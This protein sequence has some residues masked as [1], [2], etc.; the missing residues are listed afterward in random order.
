MAAI[1]AGL[2]SSRLV[3]NTSVSPVSSRT[4]SMRRST[5]GHLTSASRPLSRTSW[6]LTMLP[7]GM[8]RR[9]C[10]TSYSVCDF[11]RVTWNTPSNSCHGRWALAYDSDERAGA[12]IP[13]CASLPSQLLSPPS[14]SRSECAR[15][16]WQNIIDTS[17]LQLEK[18]LAAYSDLVFLTSDSNSGLGISLRTW[19]NMLHDAFKVGPLVCS[20]GVWRHAHYISTGWPNPRF[21]FG[22]EWSCLVQAPPRQWRRRADLQRSERA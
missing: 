20:C 8:I 10:T 17:W 13:R 9:C 15:P 21:C 1:V 19:L 7:L 14:I 4:A 6:S 5:C 16:S 11:M 12:S 2:R 3:T 18:P 22:Q